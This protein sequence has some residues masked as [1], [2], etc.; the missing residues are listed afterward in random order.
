MIPRRPEL[1]DTVSAPR[2]S[3]LAAALARYI[4]PRRLKHSENVADAA[5]D[6]AQ[7]F[8]PQLA[9]PAMVAGLLHDNAKE[10]RLEDTWA[11]VARFG[12]IVTAVE[13]VAPY[14]LHGKVGAALLPERFGVADADVSA[15]VANHVTGSAGMG[16]LSVLLYVAD[17]IAADRDFKGVEALRELAQEDLTAA[18]RQVAGNKISHSIKKGLLVE[19][20]TVDLYNYLMQEGKGGTH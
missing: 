6:L 1:T 9:G 20:A 7:R 4:G 14:L 2:R 11:A 10:M 16:L 17:Q 3:Q 5:V 12:I 19:T 18:A 13:R 15:A 8:A